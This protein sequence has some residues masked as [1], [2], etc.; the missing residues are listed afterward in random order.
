MS[1]QR[2]EA[3]RDDESGVM[4]ISRL[5]RAPYDGKLEN[6]EDDVRAKHDRSEIAR[7][8]ATCADC[9]RQKQRRADNELDLDG[10][11]RISSRILAGT[12]QEDAHA[13]GQQ[14][15]VAA[16]CIGNQDPILATST[17]DDSHEF[18]RQCSGDGEDDDTEE[19]V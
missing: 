12:D 13:K 7:R 18:L 19:D 14:E 17:A 1:H 9:S 5:S 6:N 16:D 8:S 11:D 3:D 4:M 2:L 10:V 15:D